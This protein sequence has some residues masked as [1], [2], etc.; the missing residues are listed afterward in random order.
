MSK[1]SVTSGEQLLDFIAEGID[2]FR[3]FP[4]KFNSLLRV[5]RRRVHMSAFF[6]SLLALGVTTRLIRYGRHLLEEQPEADEGTLRANV[7]EFARDKLLVHE[8]NCRDTRAL[9]DLT[10]IAARRSHTRITNAIRVQVQNAVP[11]PSCYL[12]GMA[13]TYVKNN[14]ATECDSCGKLLVAK[15]QPEPAIFE[16]LWPTAYGGDTSSANLLPACQWC[17]DKKKALASWQWAGISATLLPNS[18]SQDDWR[19]LGRTEKIAMTLRAAWDVATVDRISL[20]DALLKVGPY[21]SFHL[22][23]SEDSSDFFNMR[24]HDLES[25]RIDWSL[26]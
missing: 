20:R 5:T 7:L 15:G 10:L 4:E 23:D 9:A 16:H 25:L 6:K 17:N 2:D 22:I 24:T 8:A 1:I 21:Q 18:P 19:Q 11:E 12:C 26:S 14:A 13:L 3:A